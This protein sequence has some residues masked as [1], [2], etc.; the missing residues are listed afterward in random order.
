MPS[1]P[2]LK[3]TT[4]ASKT[5][6]FSMQSSCPQKDGEGTQEDEKVSSIV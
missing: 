3:V 1:L 4:I 2:V 6:T 5:L